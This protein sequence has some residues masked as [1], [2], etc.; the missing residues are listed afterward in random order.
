MG[1]GP[2]AVRGAAQTKGLNPALPLVHTDN[3]PNSAEAQGRHYVVLVSLNGLRWD[4]AKRENAPHLLALARE[5]AWAP[6]GMLPSYPALSFANEYTI[7][8]GLYPGRHGIVA[9][10]FVDPDINKP[11][12]SE[13]DKNKPGKQARFSI[14]DAA[15]VADGGWYGGTPLWSLA[16]KARMRTA[17]IFWPGSEA[18]IGGFRPTWYARSNA[19]TQAT[20]VLE[21]AQIDDAVALL[22]LPAGERPHL[23][24]MSFAEPEA[25]AAQFGPDA[26][27]S[28]AA[29][30]KMDS[31]IGRLK[32]ALDETGL[33]IDL[34]VVGGHGLAAVQGPW[35]SLD[36][37]ADL[38]GFDE[39]SDL[40]YAQTEQ[41]RVRVYDQLKKASSQF[42]VFRRKNVPAELNYGQNAR[43]GDPVIIATGPYAIRARKQKSGRPDQSPGT[44]IGGFDPHRVPEMRASFFAAGPDIVKA[45]TVAPFEDVNLYPWL[46]HLLGL[47]P[48]KNDGNL[49]I[50]AGTLRDSGNEA[51]DNSAH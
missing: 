40:L 39:Q 36:Q 49:N 28:R 47:A 29:V 31:L 48:V 6:D 11:E 20:A 8:T 44:G 38:N 17:C 2:L 50:L 41:D 14:T 24:M 22:H 34:V 30:L 10:D 4:Y 3:G 33:A 37:L 46:A 7:A 15:A 23:I 32:S 18:R 25:E 43:V 21:Q 12:K 5:G 1:P 26:A 19:K 9:D 51:S 13:P 27:Q 45:K 42:M 16:E 35:I